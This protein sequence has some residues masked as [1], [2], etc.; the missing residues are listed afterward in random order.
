MADKSRGDKF[1]LLI[2]RRW[3]KMLRLPALLI[4]IASGVAWWFAPDILLLA[5]HDWVPIV[6]GVIG[7]IIFFYSL[8]AQRASY[9]QCLPNY[10]KIRTPF[11]PVA[12][13]YRRILQ[14]RPI[15]FHSQF[16]PAKLNRSQR[17]LLHPFLGHTAIL[18]ELRGFPTGERR[19]RMWLPWFMFAAEVTGFVLVVEDW[20]ALTRQISTCS[21]RWVARRQARQ[22]PPSAFTP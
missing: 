8:L 14:V 3:A 6:I 17:R 21:D 16:S 9:M 22:R 20:M 12:V 10:V 18:L 13:S 7:A 1:P 15:E 11:S 4:A 2:Y 5:G 19:L